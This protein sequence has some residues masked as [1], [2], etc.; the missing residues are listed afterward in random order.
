MK[1]ISYSNKKD[2]ER[3]INGIEK[4]AN[5]PLEKHDIRQLKGKYCEFKRLRV[6]NY[7]IIFDNENNIMFIYE[8]IHRKDAYN[9]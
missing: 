8:I 2:A 5:L 4:Y 1:L 3:I 6:G 9:D 7:R